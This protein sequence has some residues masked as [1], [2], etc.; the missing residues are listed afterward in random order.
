MPTTLSPFDF[1]VTDGP[2]TFTPWTDGYAIGYQIHRTD[3]RDEY[4]YLNPSQ[5]EDDEDDHSVFLYTG[6]TGDA[7][8]DHPWH[9]YTVM[10]DPT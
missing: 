4:V 1:T 6:T 10:E 2:V 5:S 8:Y 9:F 7:A 3:G